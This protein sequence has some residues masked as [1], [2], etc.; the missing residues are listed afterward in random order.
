[1]EEE[2]I[3]MAVEA[4]PKLPQSEAI[5][6]AIIKS[7]KPLP[8][9]PDNGRGFST[10]GQFSRLLQRLSDCLVPWKWMRW[11]SWISLLGAFAARI[12]LLQRHFFAAYIM[13]IYVLNQT[14]L[15]LS[16]ATEDEDDPKLA[17]SNSGEYR[18]FVRAL[19]EFRLW[20]RGAMATVAAMAVTCFD[21]CDIDVDGRALLIY[22]TVLFALTMKQQIVH[23]IRHG[24]VPWS[25]RKPRPKTKVDRE[26]MDV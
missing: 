26:T 25:G 8:I 23:M 18:P 22:F 1:M 6:E 3:E 2:E 10:P 14:I 9:S 12:V 19:S 4:A 13:A 24:Y 11:L 15:F 17:R 5:M 7:T 20:A 16:P 21:A